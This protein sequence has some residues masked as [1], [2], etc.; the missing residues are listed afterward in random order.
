MLRPMPGD[1]RYAVDYSVAGVQ[2][3]TFVTLSIGMQV[4]EAYNIRVM[5]RSQTKFYTE[6]EFK[7]FKILGFDKVKGSSDV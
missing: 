3:S 1:Q 2:R 4:H 6:R 5:V 7:S